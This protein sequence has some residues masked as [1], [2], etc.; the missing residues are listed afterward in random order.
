[1]KRS[2]KITASKSKKNDL[3]TGYNEGAEE[4]KA[5]LGESQTTFNIDNSLSND[6]NE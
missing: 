6:K 5:W 2:A 3:R 4:N 1:V